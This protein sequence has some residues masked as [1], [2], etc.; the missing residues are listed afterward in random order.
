MTRV[1][2]YARS[3]QNVIHVVSHAAIHIANNVCHNTGKIISLC[4]L[5]V[6][7][8]FLS[9]SAMA[10]TTASTG[11]IVGTVT[12][13]T[14]AVI[15]GAKVSIRNTATNQE[16]PLTSNSAGSYNSG[17]L[18]PGTYKVQ[19]T[20]KGFSGVA[21]TVVVQVGNTATFNPKLQIGQESTVVEVQGS[22]V[23]VNTEQATVQGVI[24]A[25]QIENLPV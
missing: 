18:E 19:V 20:A 4:A 9:V 10:Q 1:S 21:E 16:I 12:D 23:Q 2:S 5:G 6:L 11:T 24:T 15:G 3:S 8:M 14:G 25:S 7:V 22:E 13:P 17:A